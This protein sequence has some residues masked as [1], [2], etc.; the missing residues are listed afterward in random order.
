MMVPPSLLALTA[1]AGA[2][3]TRLETWCALNSGSGN[4]AGLARMADVLEAALLELTPEVSRVPVAADGRVALVA[5]QRPQA[6]VR[7]L[8]SG[9]YDTVYEA[10]SPFQQCTR[11][12]AHTLQGPGV[13]D[14]KGGLVVMMAALRAFEE[15]PGSEALGWDVVLTPD[16]EIGSAASRPLLEAQA[17]HCQLGL[18]FEPARE[19]GDMVE[20]RKG[21]GI[22]TV[23]CHGR[24]AHAGRNPDDGRNAILA[25]A[26]Y[27][28]AIE[29]LPTELPGV[30]LNVGR[31]RG[32]GTVNVVPD[33]AEAELNARSASIAAARSFEAELHRRAEPIRQREG[34]RLEISGCFNRPPMERTPLADRLRPVLQAT[35]QALNLPAFDW[36]HVG[37]GSDGNLFQAVGLPCLDG[38][39][40][41]GGHLHSSREYVDLPSLVQRTQLAALFLHQLARG[42][43]RIAGSQ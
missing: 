4:L 20:S 16:E 27:L 41:I 35:A 23:T 14:M 9:H 37:G 6:L 2:L 40:P 22:F 38:L 39:G 29:S 11:I 10:D 19:N 24:A 18:L 8:C 5:R 7:V 3:Q 12:N 1:E 30:M 26:E 17:Q 21:T 36:V 34:Y 25:L 33:F 13:A 28:L 31:I 32:G 42:E 15:L 43:A